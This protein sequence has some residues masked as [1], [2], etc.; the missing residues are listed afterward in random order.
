MNTLTTVKSAKPNIVT[1]KAYDP[2]AVKSLAQES[3]FNLNL[4]QRY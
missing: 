2:E 1:C 4:A 3:F